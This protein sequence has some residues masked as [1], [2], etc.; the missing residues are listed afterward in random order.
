MLYG[1]GTNVPASR[2]IIPPPSSEFHEPASW[3]SGQ[4]LLTTN[5]EVPGSEVFTKYLWF[6]FSKGDQPRGLVVRVS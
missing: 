2:I 4:G 6:I 1:F 5:P 3:S